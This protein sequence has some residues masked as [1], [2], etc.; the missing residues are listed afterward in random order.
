MFSSVSS[1]LGSFDFKDTKEKPQ[2][3]VKSMAM[4]EV[5]SLTR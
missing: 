5:V 2:E 1:L 4:M 3:K